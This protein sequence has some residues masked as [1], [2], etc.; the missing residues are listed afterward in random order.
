MPALEL[1]PQARALF[2]AERGALR[3][4][5]ADRKRIAVALTAR[6]GAGAFPFRV[7]APPSSSPSPSPAPASGH[8][9]GWPTLSVMAGVVV[10]G[11]LV[12]STLRASELKAPPVVITTAQAVA[13]A[14]SAAPASTAPAPD[15]EAATPPGTGPASAGRRAPDRLAEEVAILSRAET[16]LHAGR[17]QGAL[18]VLEEYERK[19]HNGK[20]AQERA[21][22]RILALC[23]LGRTTEANA[24]LARLSRGSLHAGTAR[25]ACAKGTPR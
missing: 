3:P 8:W 7:D 24:A 1:G 19:F 13:P 14:P 18:R 10:T 6:L 20:L 21:A 2:E 5:S 25:E 9:F 22:A 12:L 15:V 17:Y 11:G 4:T 23:G 16:E